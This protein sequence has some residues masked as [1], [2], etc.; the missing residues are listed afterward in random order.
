LPFAVINNYG[1]TEATVVATYGQVLPTAHAEVPPS[2]G[3][4]IANTQIY[5]LDD[6]LQRVPIGATGELYIGGAG[7]AKGYLNRPELTA[8]RFIPNP[9]SNEPESRLYKTGDLARY[10]PDGQL[11]FLGRS[12]H[13]VKIRG[14]RIEL[15]EIEAVLNQHPAVRQAAVIVR[16]DVPDEKHLGA[17]IVPARG[18]DVTIGSLQDLLATHLPDYMIPTAFVLLE[19]LPLTPNGKVDRSVLPA[20]DA[21]NTV[22]DRAIVAPSTPTEER[23]AEIVASLL[24]LEQVGVDQNYFLLGGNSLLGTQIILRVAEA[25]AVDLSLLNLFEAPTVRELSAEIERLIFAELEALN[26]EELLRLLP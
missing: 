21:T 5:I 18:A 10:L 25:F 2:I 11:T 16:E 23:L 3:R 14:Y 22:R 1:P 26:D 12:D 6:H 13:Q 17:Y 19:A 24:S 8:E 20:P 4:P 9:F 7:L 15:G